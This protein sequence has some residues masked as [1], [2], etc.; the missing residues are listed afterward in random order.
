MFVYYA[1]I[2]CRRDGFGKTEENVTEMQGCYR[3]AQQKEKLSRVWTNRSF[4]YGYATKLAIES[5]VQITEQELNLLVK[6]G[7]LTKGSR[8]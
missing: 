6:L 7:L 8:K 3:E 5:I 1:M 4:D 2:P